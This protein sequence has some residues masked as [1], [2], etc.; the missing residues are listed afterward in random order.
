M[1]A[2]KKPTKLTQE[3][4]FPHGGFPYR[5]EYKDENNLT[6]LCWFQCEHHLTTHVNRYKITQGQT[7]VA[8]GN[9]PLTTETAKKKAFSNLDT[10]FESR[11]TPSVQLSTPEHHIVNY[12]KKHLLRYLS[13]LR[14][15]HRLG[16]HMKH[17]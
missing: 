15:N 10:F 5:L 11:T 6:R 16:Y 13:S 7:H 14:M 9:D 1:P 12:A 8:E 4:L 17:Y 2:K 3:E